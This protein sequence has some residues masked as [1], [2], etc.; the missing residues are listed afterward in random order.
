MEIPDQSMACKS[1][2]TI[3]SDCSAINATR[4]TLANLAF[5]IGHYSFTVRA[6]R[7]CVLRMCFG[8]RPLVGLLNGALFALLTSPS[9]LL[10]MHATRWLGSIKRYYNVL[11]GRWHCHWRTGY[12]SSMADMEVILIWWLF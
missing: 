8:G 3:Q 1:N 5:R 9:L 10:A 2:G 4:S 12:L 7:Y 11:L 6:D